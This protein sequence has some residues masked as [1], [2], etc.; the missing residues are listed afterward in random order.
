MGEA[1]LRLQLHAVLVY[2]RQGVINAGHLP[3][4][5]GKRIVLSRGTR[6]RLQV[7]THDRANNVIGVVRLAQLVQPLDR[8]EQLAGR[9]VLLHGLDR[10][11]RQRRLRINDCDG[12][13]GLEDPVAG[14]GETV[15]QL[16][17]TP[18]VSL[19]GD[20]DLPS[21]AVVG[22]YG[23]QIACARGHQGASIGPDMVGYV[24]LRLRGEQ[25]PIRSIDDVHFRRSSRRHD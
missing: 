10:V 13:I 14:A 23:K 4:N 17:P 19:L 20:V 15:R 9:P 16:E 18:V 21:R 8:Y 3:A 22:G 25:R 12:I 5:P 24:Q 2:P 1:V 11:V 6:I 7:E